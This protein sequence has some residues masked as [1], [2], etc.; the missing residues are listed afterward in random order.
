MVYHHA[1]AERDGNVLLHGYLP[2]CIS[3]A[4]VRA[5]RR[6]SGVDAGYKYRYGYRYRYSTV[7]DRYRQT[8]PRIL[9]SDTKYRRILSLMEV[10][11]PIRPSHPS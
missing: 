9:Q 8:R 4:T 11:Y 1:A 5:R 2:A 10:S 6:G 3:V 7:T